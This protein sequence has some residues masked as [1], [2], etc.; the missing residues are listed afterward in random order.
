MTDPTSLTVPLP[1]AESSYLVSQ[2]LAESEKQQLNRVAELVEQGEPGRI[3]LMAILRHRQSSPPTLVDGKI[4][5]TLYS[6]PL[7][8]IQDFLQTHFPQ[9]LIVLQSDRHIDYHLLQKLLAQQDFQT[10]DSVTREKFCEL[11]GEA[12]LK[13]KWVYFTDVEQFPESDLRT[14]DT[15]WWLHSEG[16]FG[17]R[18]QRQI[19]NSLGQD[20]VK[21]W[22][23][24]GWKSGNIWTKFPQGFTWNLSAPVGHLPLLNQLRG[25]R[26][27]AA[28]FNHPVWSK[29]NDAPSP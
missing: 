18:V 8:H 4:Y 16:R 10:A 20:F 3:A 13:R 27:A 19:W 24:I 14:I 1:E 26:V 7:P 6:L 29:I 15:L 5:Q 28:L 11:A 2:F 21:L 23:K 9:G 25:V 22:P 17:F 12:A